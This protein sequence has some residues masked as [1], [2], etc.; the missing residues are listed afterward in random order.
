M[1]TS[2]RLIL[3]YSLISFFL[4]IAMALYGQDKPKFTPTEIQLLKLQNKQKDALLAKSRLE[5]L[6]TA[7]QNAQ[8]D[9][10][11]SMKALGDEAEAVKKENGWPKEVNF[12]PNTVSFSEPAKEA[13]K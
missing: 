9:F 13:K 6:Q 8:K 11:D 2:H 1:K 5:A 7:V 3:A 4:L 10:Q 12:D